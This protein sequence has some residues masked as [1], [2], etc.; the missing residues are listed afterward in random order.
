MLTLEKG[1]ATT[2]YRLRKRDGRL[3]AFHRDKLVQS[4][5]M[6]GL[7]AEPAMAIAAEI[8]FTDGQSSWMLRGAVVARLRRLDPE[9]ARRFE[10][11]RR[12]D[13]TSSREV[14]RW[15]V[16]LHAATLRESGLNPGMPVRV[17]CG[18]DDLSLLVELSNRT[19]IRAARLNPEL[20]HRLGICPGSRLA[21]SWHDR[22]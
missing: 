11:T 13:A 22:P 5:A 16:H 12:F 4:L 20:L 8:A 6:L 21:L 3:V 2:S 14:R 7:E 9:L 15:R 19:A 18:G 10:F 1:R 17:A